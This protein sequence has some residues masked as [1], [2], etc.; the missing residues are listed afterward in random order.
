[1]GGGYTHDNGSYSEYPRVVLATRFFFSASQ[2]EP[3]PGPLLTE[4]GGERGLY[5]MSKQEKL[6]SV[7]IAEAAR[8]LGISERTVYRRIKSGDIRRDKVSDREAVARVFCEGITVES[9]VKMSDTV[10]FPQNTEVAAIRAEVAARDAQIE[11]LIAN[12][13]EMNQT[14]QQLNQQLYELAR[15]IFAS[16]SEKNEKKTGLLGQWLRKWKPE[17][18][19][20]P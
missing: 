16:E 12:Q 1:M 15:L 5:R 18:Q 9:V 19:E 14:I 2:P 13:R 3:P 6:T 7:P 17:K 8:I 20:K 4:G 10:D 11:S